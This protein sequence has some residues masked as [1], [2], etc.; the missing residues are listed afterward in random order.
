MPNTLS[1]HTGFASGVMMMHDGTSYTPA[2]SVT[3]PIRK[4][5]LR[6][7][8]R[9]SSVAPLPCMTMMPV[10][11]AAG[12]TIPPPAFPILPTVCISTISCMPRN[13]AAPPIIIPPPLILEEPTPT[14]QRSLSLS[15]AARSTMQNPLYLLRTSAM[16]ASSSTGGSGQAMSARG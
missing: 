7:P 10:V 8:Q 15:A 9:E 13:Q 5:L 1:N 11:V 16:T 3:I 2:V 6:L 4:W 12:I 14:R